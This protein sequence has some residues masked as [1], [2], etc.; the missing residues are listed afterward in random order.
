MA[1]FKRLVNNDKPAEAEPQHVEST[2]A[3]S[4]SRNFKVSKTGDGDVALALFSSPDD[5]KEPIDPLEEKKLV[6]KIDLMILP[7]LAVCYV[8]FYIDKTT[9][10][11]AAIFDIDEDL[12]LKGN[13][14]NWLR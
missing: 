4:S 3:T 2:N 13:Q 1:I 6:R 8:F 5:A 10:S 11:Y 9:L 12:K 14:Y 7:L